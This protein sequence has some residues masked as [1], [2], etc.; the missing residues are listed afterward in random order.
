MTITRLDAEHFWLIGPAAGEWHDRDWLESHLPDDAGFTLANVTGRWGTLV[1][2]GPRARDV[3]G[4]VTASDLS[5]AAFPWLSAQPIEIGPARGLAFRVTYVG[6]LGWELHL[7]VEALAPVYDLLWA[8]G[9]AHG[10]ADFGLYAMDSLRLEKGYRAWKQDLG[11]EYSPLASA[12][13]RFIRLDKPAFIGRDALLQE[14]QAGPHERFVPLIVEAG[15]AD[16]PFCATVWQGARR[17][18]LVTSGGYGHRLG[19]SIA[20]AYVE[21]PLAV[22]GTALEIDIYGERCPARVA[23]EPLYDPT[24]ERLRA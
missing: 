5:S 22:E 7:P 11:R 2:A 24:N 3:L 15:A 8:A 4:Q 10:I 21:T 14:Q 13:E 9:E 1:L 20:L 6:E 16:A 12:L 17:V 18:G 23:R 19:R